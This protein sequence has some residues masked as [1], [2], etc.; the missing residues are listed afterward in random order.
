M[1]WKGFV[2]SVNA[3]VNR[4]KRESERQARQRQKE[5]ESQQ[6]LAELESAAYEVELYENYIERLKSV[7]KDCSESIDWSSIKNIP[8]PSEPVQKSTNEQNAQAEYDNFK[9]G[10]LD[11][12]LN[13]TEKRLDSL[14]QKISEAKLLDERE[15]QILQDEYQSQY[16][17]W[18]E[19]K[20]LAERV[21]KGDKNAYL[22]VINE[23]NPFSEIAELGSSLNFKIGDTG[24]IE[25]SIN[26][27]GESLIPTESKSLLRNGKLSA[28]K[29]PKGTYYELH[30]DYIC[31]CVIRVANELFAILPVDLVIVSAI[32][33][34][35]NT[36]SGHMEEQPILSV[37]ISRKTLEM[38]NL[39]QIDPSD[40]M[41]NFVHKMNFKKSSGFSPVQ[42][43]NPS[44]L[45]MN[46]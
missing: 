5:L 8:P 20:S 32:D 3:S 39:E 19:S 15:F 24:I 30:Q 45:P 14:K 17:D 31:S 23:M 46:K 38:L 35:L 28:K 10:V 26:V 21:L 25:T 43:I 11:K 41:K 22:E 34:I 6:R 29:L 16:K 27:H 18:E 9:P 1:S 36:A 4:A 44:D 13:T 2:R 33:N 42:S 7:H 37:A 40:S 12:L